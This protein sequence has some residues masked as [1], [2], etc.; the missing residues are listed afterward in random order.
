MALDKDLVAIQEVRDLLNAAHLAQQEFEG[1]SQE[2]VDRVVDAMAHA[3]QREIEAVSRLA[4]EETGMGVYEDKVVKTRFAAETIYEYIRPLRTVG[5]LSDNPETGVV[6]IAQPMGVVAAIIP[7]TNPTSTAIYKILISLKARNAIVIS[8][9]PRAKR[10]IQR[11]AEIMTE[12]ARGAGA[13]EGLIACLSSPTLESTQALMSHPRTGVILA[14]GGSGLVRAAYSSG[15]PAFGVGPGNVPAYIDRTADVAQATH[16]ILTGTAFDNGTIC[17]SEQ[18]AVVDS[19]VE[20]EAIQ[21]FEAVGGYFLNDEEKGRLERFAC[22]P[23]AKLNSE[24]AGQHAQWIAQRAGITVPAQTRLLIA[25]LDKVGREEPL[26]IEKLSPIIGF[27]TVRDWVEGC[28]RCMELLRF[29]GMGHTLA[30]HAGDDSIIREFGLK[31]PAFRIV[32]NSPSTFGSIG[33]STGLVPAMTLGCGAVGGN[34][35][36][37]NVSPLHLINV[38][39]LAYGRRKVELPPRA[40]EG[41]VGRAYALHETQRGETSVPAGKTSGHTLSE[42][43]VQRIVDDF[44]EKRKSGA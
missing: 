29:G 18:A 21:G 42:S 43:D 23:G 24:I 15:K 6:E 13:P 2:Q 3:A 5:E 26:S 4:V 9:H 36:G 16:D 17:A 20:Q 27:Y 12:A 19:V 37:D 44:L 41:G 25:R 28:E 38:K 39:R 31:K 22:R 8:P 30:I 33:Y 1:F 11:C 35:T 40:S 32:V 10:C 14:T 7:T 34:I